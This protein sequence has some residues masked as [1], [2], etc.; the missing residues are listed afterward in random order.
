[1]KVVRAH[2]G[3]RVGSEP[4][5][6]FV[7]AKLDREEKIAKQR[8]SVIDTKDLPGSVDRDQG[9]ETSDGLQKK[10]DSVQLIV[11]KLDGE[12]QELDEGIEEL[13]KKKM[14]LVKTHEEI[15]R[16]KEWLID[17]IELEGQMAGLSLLQRCEV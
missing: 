2:F 4:V 9:R 5:D 1:M 13:E 6:P 14:E 11:K 3:L 10:L 8:G 15:C 7:L 12:I 17:A 16:R